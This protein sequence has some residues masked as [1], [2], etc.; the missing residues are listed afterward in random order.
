MGTG[1][2]VPCVAGSA[3][4]G[5]CGGSFGENVVVPFPIDSLA[6]LACLQVAQR[7]CWITRI[8]TAGADTAE[9]RQQYGNSTRSP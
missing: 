2:D 1:A 3:Q 8:V 5:R 6:V 9:I 7:V 4:H